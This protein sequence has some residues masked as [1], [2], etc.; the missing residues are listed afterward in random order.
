MRSSGGLVFVSGVRLENGYSATAS[1]FSA[2]SRRRRCS[3]RRAGGSAPGSRSR[4]PG[5]WSDQQ[6][7]LGM[8]GRASVPKKYADG[9]SYWALR[10][11]GAAT[12][13]DRWARAVRPGVVYWLIGR[14]DTGLLLA[15]PLCS[16]VPALTTPVLSVEASLVLEVPSRLAG[17]RH[18]E[19]GY[20]RRRTRRRLSIAMFGVLAL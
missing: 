13:A 19:E 7:G 4:L 9:P 14:G 10:S 11:L 8:I 12:M 18:S 17:S 15:A 16:S 5:A 20:G 2:R 1:S 6:F 3:R